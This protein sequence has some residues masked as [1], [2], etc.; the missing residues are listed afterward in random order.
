MSALL[1]TALRGESLRH[2]IQTTGPK[3]SSTHT[4][5]HAHTH[6][7]THISLKNESFFATPQLVISDSARASLASVLSGASGSLESKNRRITRDRTPWLVFKT[8]G[9]DAESRINISEGAIAGPDLAKFSPK[10]PSSEAYRRHTSPT[11]V[12][13]YVFTSGTT[14]L[15]KAAK[16]IHARFYAAGAAFSIFNGLVASDRIYCAL[17][18]YHSAGGMIGVSMAVFTGAALIISKNFSVRR[19]FREC[20]DSRATVVQYIGQICR[21]LVNS[22]ATDADRRAHRVNKAIGNGL[23]GDTWKKFQEKFGIGY[24][25]EFY[26]ATEGNA[27]LINNQS[28]VGAVG[29]VPGIADYLPC[30]D[31]PIKIIKVDPDTGAPL[32][33]RDGLCVRC[34]ADEPGELVSRIQ[35]NNVDRRFDGYL[36]AAATKKKVLTNVFRK[37]D[38]WFRSGDLLRRDAKGYFFFVDRLGDTFRW[39]GENVATSEVASAIRS[40]PSPRVA[41]VVVYGVSVPNC[42][43]KA[44][45]ACLQ[46]FDSKLSADSSTLPTPAGLRKLWE[47]CHAHLPRYAVPVFLRVRSA[48]ESLDVTV[49]FKHM[50]RALVKEGFSV[51][52]ADAVYVCCNAKRTWVPFGS[53]ELRDVMEGKMRL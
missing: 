20:A 18:L 46:F 12:L 7:H 22:P 10:Q 14:G 36:D 19:F 13:F 39:K 24:V 25:G 44:G 16:I 9:D 30:V 11:S 47:H 23:R 32:R 2:C 17:P 26:A 38:C 1:N 4:R 50:R 33:D 35:S 8:S 42:D 37:G 28:R 51:S 45:M 6:T 48:A 40:C 53:A 21:Y 29:Y 41:D 27:V 5:A 43:G 31:Y 34:G 15:P 49:T 3:V 52:G